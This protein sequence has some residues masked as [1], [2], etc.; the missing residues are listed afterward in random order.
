MLR[1]LFWR[2]PMNES[3]WISIKE[4]QDLAIAIYPTVSAY[5]MELEECVPLLT[6]SHWPHKI[7]GNLSILCDVPK[8]FVQYVMSCKNKTIEVTQDL[9]IVQL[10]ITHVGGAANTLQDF[11][12]F[13]SDLQTMTLMVS[14]EEPVLAPSPCALICSFN[15]T[16]K[17]FRVLKSC[18]SMAD[19]VA[20]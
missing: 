13:I 7:W 2:C 1:Y 17:L 6:T 8:Y 14:T 16:I 19:Y 15:Y 12:G 18:F 10:S 9:Q 11:Q 3:W 20:K 5:L 4:V